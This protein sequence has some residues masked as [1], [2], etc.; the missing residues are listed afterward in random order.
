[1]MNVVSISFIASMA[2]PTKVPPETLAAASA[3]TATGG[4]RVEKTAK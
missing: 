2:V 4:V 1:M 3:L